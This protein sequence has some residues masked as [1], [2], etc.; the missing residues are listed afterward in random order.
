M[1]ESHAAAASP[2]TRSGLKPRFSTVSGAQPGGVWRAAL[3]VVAAAVAG[4]ANSFSVPFLL[5]DLPAIVDNATLR[6]FSFSAVLTPPATAGVGGRPLAN[7]SFALNRAFGGTAVFGYHAVNLA[8]HAA[9]A[10]VL[11][12]LVRRTLLLSGARERFGGAATWLSCATALLWL[13][14]PVQ[15]EAVTYLSQRTELLAGFFYFLTLYGFVRSAG[16]A[17]DSRW[18]MVSVAACLLGGLSKEIVVT[19]PVAVLLFDR[20]FVAGS[21]SGAWQSRRGYYLALAS[22][23]AVI[24]W[25]LRDVAERGVGFGFAITW[26]DYALTSCRS[27]VHYLQRGLWPYPLIFDYGTEVVRQAREV[28]F[29]LIAV[30]VLVAATV[31]ALWRWPKRGFVA[32]WFFLT[33]APTT[34]V[35]PVAMQPLA[36]HRLYLP[37]AGLATGFVL[38]LYCGLGRRSAWFGRARVLR[39]GVRADIRKPGVAPPARR[40]VSCVAT[41]AGGHPTF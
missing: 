17:G 8:L 7:L 32:A 20:A 38:A 18:K 21:F 27:L 15:T 26:F 1:S 35:I 3:L 13:L 28:A 16:P 5:D 23:W 37:L 10:L 25:L 4:Y 19:A 40:S 22:S 41:G 29:H 30:L 36:E 39:A 9:A 6:D 24:A 33:L 2:E 11:L 12:G 14:H 34:S 31:G